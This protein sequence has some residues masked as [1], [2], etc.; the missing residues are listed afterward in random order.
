MDQSIGD[1][2]VQINKAP[3]DAKKAQ[4]ISFKSCTVQRVEFNR[5]AQ[6]PT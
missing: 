3:L 5:A 4:K 6:K 2:A 1:Q